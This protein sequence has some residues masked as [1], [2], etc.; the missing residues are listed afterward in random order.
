MAMRLAQ[1]PRATNALARRCFSDAKI[2]YSARQAAKGRP[3]SP[4]VTIYSFPVVSRQKQQR[5]QSATTAEQLGGSRG[6]AHS[7]QDKLPG[8]CAS[9]SRVIA[10]GGNFRPH[11]NGGG[12]GGARGSLLARSLA[13]SPARS[14]APVPAHAYT[15][16]VV[17]A[18]GGDLIHRRPRDGCHAHHRHHGH[19]RAQHRKN[20]RGTPAQE[21]EGG[22]SAR[23]RPRS[24]FSFFCSAP[25]T[26][27]SHPTTLA[28]ALLTLRA[29]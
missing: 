13:C 14:P 18:S 15:P 8:A 23:S 7:A 26:A 21:E 4:H 25:G 22:F 29:S 16:V 27:A 9:V 5:R 12:G 6:R 17:A 1:L 28:V 24:F 19:R 2:P 3:V 10:T 11:A 20:K